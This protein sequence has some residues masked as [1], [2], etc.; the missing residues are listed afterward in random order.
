MRTFILILLSF[1][2]TGCYTSLHVVQDQPQRTV[3]TTPTHVTY[4][5]HP[6]HYNR[7]WVH[8]SYVYVPRYYI[9]TQPKPTVRNNR[10]V[11]QQPRSSGLRNQT[12]EVRQPT[13]TTRVQRE[14]P[15]QRVRST[16]PTR[17]RGE[18]NRSS[19]TRTDRSSN[20]RTRN[21]N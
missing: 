16:P 14:R 1:F 11:R 13:R 17:T 5:Y 18:V 21:N 2:L 20:R 12:R 8:N 10:T 7:I 15:P 9:H 4:Y 19:N 3:I 6:T